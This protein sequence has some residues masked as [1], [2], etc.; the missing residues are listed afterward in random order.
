MSVEMS[1][2]GRH[3]RLFELQL[4]TDRTTR[5]TSILKSK[6]GFGS[7]S[8]QRLVQIQNHIGEHGPRR[9]LSLIR[10]GV[11]W[12]KWCFRKLSSIFR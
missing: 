9:V 11:Q 1:G 10:F 4:H 6:L 3:R 12:P 5:L 8:R 2:C 7:G